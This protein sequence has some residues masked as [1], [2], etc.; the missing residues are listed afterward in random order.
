MCILGSDP[1]RHSF[2]R[3]EEFT[4]PLAL[5]FKDEVPLEESTQ[6]S[7]CERLGDGC[8]IRERFEVILR[9]GKQV[10]LR[11]GLL[12][13]SRKHEVIA[14]DAINVLLTAVGIGEKVRFGDGSDSGYYVAAENP[15][16][17]RQAQMVAIRLVNT[18]KFATPNWGDSTRQRY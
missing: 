10:L 3:L 7:R 9:S 17:R 15:A 2:G 14:L 12:G 13:T 16:C 8:E 4:S 11:C 1:K 5:M 6:F 18:G